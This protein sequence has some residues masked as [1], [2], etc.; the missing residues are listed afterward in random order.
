MRERVPIRDLVRILEAVTGAGAAARDLDT[1][2]E[3]ARRAIGPAICAQIAGD[4]TLHAITLDPRLEQHLFENLRAGEKGAYLAIAPALT[5]AL[6]DE[7]TA[8]IAAAENRGVRPVL[9]CTDQLRPVLRRLLAAGW[10]SLPVIAFGELSS[11][12]NLETTGVIRVDLS[13]ATV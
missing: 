6:L 2:V 5:E 11:N 9:L 7:A 12:L 13:H 3:A 10:P 4:G 1:M 8:V